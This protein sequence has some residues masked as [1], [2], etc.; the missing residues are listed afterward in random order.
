LYTSIYQKGVKLK[1]SSLM[2]HNFQTGNPPGVF[3]TKLEAAAGGMSS[4]SQRRGLDGRILYMSP[5]LYLK[6]V[7][8]TFTAYT[9]V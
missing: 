5:Y 8:E 1:L 3:S 2:D 9:A 6:G 7:C 4:S